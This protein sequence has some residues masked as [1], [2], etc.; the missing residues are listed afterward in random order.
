[1]T[2]FYQMVLRA[3]NFLSLGGAIFARPGPLDKEAAPKRPMENADG[4][5][6]KELEATSRIDHGLEKA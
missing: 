4:K 1:M 6:I 5:S 2:L 3:T